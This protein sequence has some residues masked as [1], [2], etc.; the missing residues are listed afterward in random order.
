MKRRR[1]TNELMAV[2]LVDH[3]SHVEADLTD[4]WQLLRSEFPVY[5]H[6]PT[7]LGPGFWVVSRYADIVSIYKDTENFTSEQGNVLVTL[8]A[9]TDS[10]AGQMLP[11]TDGPRH[12]DLR[13]L[14][15]KAFSPRALDRV[16]EA[17]QA[18][19]RRLVAAAIRRGESDV[20]AEVAAHVPSIT[21]AK[22]LGVPETDRPH[23]LRLTMSALS[24]ER[25][26]QSPEEAWLARNEILVYFGNLLASKRE[27]PAD[28]VIST[29]AHAE[30]DGVPLTDQD[31]V[32]NCY[33]LVLGGDETSRLAIADAVDTLAR[34]PAQWE[35]LRAGTVS[36]DSATEEVLRWS[37]P[38]MNFGR[39]A[40]QDVHVAGQE[41]RAGDLV[42][43]WVTSANRDEA[44]FPDPY[45]FDLARSPNKHLSFGHGPHFCLGAFLSRVEIRE[46]LDALRTFSKGF[47]VF[48]EPR[49]IHSNFMTGMAYLPVRF[50]PD[51]AALDAAEL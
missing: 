14:M 20:V 21:I 27:N 39:T 38:A 48:G 46:V 17:V 50:E 25:A 51:E 28:D 43:M 23:L 33:S 10:A 9:G 37:T 35:L 3:R 45:V 49:R 47:E 16:A 4:Y 41:F 18:N 34:H 2:N 31:I 8:L 29:L 32:L 36:L 11:V 40:V 19:T 44:V 30:L 1:L 24:S 7:E 26:D 12:R 15:L 22:L 5:W 6:A 42:T 13:N